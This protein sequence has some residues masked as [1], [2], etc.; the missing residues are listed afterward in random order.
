MDWQARAVAAEAERDEALGLLREAQK[1]G[2]QL[3]RTQRAL[4]KAEAELETLRAALRAIADSQSWK[5]GD[6]TP[7][8]RAR[9]ALAGSSE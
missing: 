6:P 7:G 3:A 2:T 9:A 8:E 1:S 4:H 5:H